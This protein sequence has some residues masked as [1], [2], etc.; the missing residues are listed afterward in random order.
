MK[1]F[2]FF[3]QVSEISFS[4]KHKKFFV[5]K[6]VFFFS[7]IIR[8]YFHLENL[9]FSEKYKKFFRESIRKFFFKREKL[10]FSNG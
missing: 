10:V 3:A 8:N 2:N 6:T 4:D 9:F 5:W 7:V 1:R